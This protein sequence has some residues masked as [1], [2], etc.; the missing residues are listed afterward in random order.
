MAANHHTRLL[1]HSKF[2]ARRLN[3]VLLQR[4]TLCPAASVQLLYHGQDL[5]PFACS[6]TPAVE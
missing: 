5:G 2:L 6:C 4:E 3:P 1:L